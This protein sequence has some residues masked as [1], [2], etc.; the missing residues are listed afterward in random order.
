MN[1]TGQAVYRKGGRRNRKKPSDR[2]YLDWLKTQSSA[3]SGRSPCDPCHY[4]TAKNSGIGCKP[5]FSAIPL[6]REEHREQHRIGQFNFQSREW[7]E[8]QVEIHLKRWRE[9]RTPPG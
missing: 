3:L 9:S 4:R 8:E 1:L 6:T 7:W 5:L 2:E